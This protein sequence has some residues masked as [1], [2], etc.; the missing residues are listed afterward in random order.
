M[1]L[2]MRERI[3]GMQMDENWTFQSSDEEIKLQRDYLQLPIP[4]I[5]VLLNSP[6]CYITAM[7]EDGVQ[8]VSLL[9]PTVRYGKDAE[10]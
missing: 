7:G 5:L 9:T 6:G 3:G 8:R 10:C 4:I 1:K 2:S